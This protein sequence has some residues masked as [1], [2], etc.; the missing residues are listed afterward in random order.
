MAQMVY[1]NFPNIPVVYKFQLRSK[2]IN[3]KEI[4]KSIKDEIN[5][6]AGINFIRD[7][8]RYLKSI[9]FLT[10]DFINWL[11]HFQFQ[12]MKH[13]NITESKGNFEL[14]ITGNWLDT[15]LYEVPVLA[16]IS[17]TYHNNINPLKLKECSNRLN[18]KISLIKNTVNDEF[19][20]AD[21]GTRRRNS[22]TIQDFVVEQLSKQLPNNFVGTSNVYFAKKYN[23]KPIGT[24]AH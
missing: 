19:K 11:E 17:E 18:N 3:L 1:H 8:I 24:M 23:I 4:T 12:P 9:P 7:E 20:F 16:I 14:T 5:Q 13:I 21:F 15:I 2:G 6:L 22:F 10:Y